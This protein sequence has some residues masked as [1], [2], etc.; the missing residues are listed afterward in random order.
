MFWVPSTQSSVTSLLRHMKRTAVQGST[1]IIPRPIGARPLV[2][3]RIVW[4]QSPCVACGYG[5]GTSSFLRHRS[6][7]ST[8]DD[9]ADDDHGKYYEQHDSPLCS[10]EWRLRA[11]CSASRCCCRDGFLYLYTQ[12]STGGSFV[13]E[14]M[15]SAGV[16]E[17]E[18]IHIVPRLINPS[19]EPLAS[20][21][22]TPTYLFLSR[23][24]RRQGRNEVRESLV[25]HPISRFEV[26]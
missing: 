12:A 22:R 14:R 25:L 21:I 9:S 11:T 8:T 15:Q 24:H 6:S 5:L 17:P 19:T 26:L 23:I 16:R 10:P 2:G 18:D 4:P 1:T 3:I 13:F 20:C 7:N